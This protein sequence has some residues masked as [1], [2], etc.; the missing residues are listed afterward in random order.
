MRL[1][2]TKRPKRRHLRIPNQTRVFAHH[3]RRLSRR[4]DEEVYRQWRFGIGWIK[5]SCGAG[6][7]ESAAWLLKKHS[8]ATGANEPGDRCPSSM[9]AQTISS[10]A[11]S[12]LVL[13]AASIELWPAF[14]KSEHW[15]STDTERDRALLLIDDQPLN[16]PLVFRYNDRQRIRRD[17]DLKLS[18]R[19][20]L[21]SGERFELTSRRRPCLLNDRAVV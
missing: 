11:V 7:I 1:Q 8:P 19:D 2:I 20:S 21:R 13:V 9:R 15:T 3:Y 6:K 12:H 17:R 16:Q 14:T 5:S 10:L 18:E 4:N